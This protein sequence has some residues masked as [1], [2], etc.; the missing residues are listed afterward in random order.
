M[1]LTAVPPVA[2][3]TTPRLAL[4]AASGSTVA[5]VP[6]NGQP[7]G[8][9]TP[10]PIL[11]PRLVL[12]R[13]GRL[14]GVGERTLLADLAG[15]E[16]PAPGVT[17]TLQ[18][19][20]FHGD[21]DRGGGPQRRI[22]AWRESRWVANPTGPGPGVTAVQFRHEFGPE[23]ESGIDT[24]TDY[25]RLEVTVTGLDGPDEEPLY[26]LS[27]DFALLLENEWIVELPSVLQEAEGA[28]PEELLIYYSDMF[29]ARRAGSGSP[30]WLLRREVTDYVEKAFVPAALAAFRLQSDGWKFPWHL[31]W[32]AHGSVGGPKQLAVALAPPDTWYHG[33]APGNG[34]AGI[35][36]N[37]DAVGMGYTTLLDGMMSTFHHELFHNL[38]R[39]LYQHHGLAHEGAWDMVTEG[40]AM[41]ASSVAQPEVQFGQSWGRRAYMASASAYIGDG[42][43]AA[44]DMNTSY[45]EISYNGA[46]YWRFLYER[47]AV[48]SRGVE[49]PAAG[50]AV[51]RRV[52]DALYAREAARELTSDGFV[53]AFPG[54]IDEALQG[55]SCSVQSHEESLVAFARAIYAL[56]LEGGRCTEET[57]GRE[58][59]GFYDPNGL[60]PRPRADLVRYAGHPLTVSSA[61]QTPPAGIASSYGIDLVEVSL[62]GA[63]HGGPLTIE[64]R[65][66]PAGSAEFRLEVWPVMAAGRRLLP[67]A[68][69]P[70]AAVRRPDGSLSFSLPSVDLTRYNRLGLIITRVDS[71][72]SLD[73]VGAYT[74]V[75]SGTQ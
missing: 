57:Y 30:P 31:A 39:G 69:A 9:A 46:A 38:Q 12:R 7:A 56:R 10:E 64:L 42:G 33:Q 58:G 28:A 4:W 26:T 63:A 11:L 35:S 21:P 13:N 24:P 72:E 2:A 14:T 74:L 53:R 68:L 6:G 18:L 61:Q 62:E 29:P 60:Y 27:N 40:M 71:G 67:A 70:E 43:V 75:L 73:P 51:M 50:M 3:S 36:I 41:L 44:G 17:V 22:V 1:A 37:I 32:T 25:Y 8:E 54:I 47:C 34:H 48:D 19:E 23:L 20:T 52:L 66:I 49:D 16:V 5:F 59:C 55:S 65:G 15:L 45:G